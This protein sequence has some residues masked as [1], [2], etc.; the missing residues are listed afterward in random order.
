MRL[1]NREKRLVAYLRTRN[2]N[3]KELAATLNV[4]Q[5][6]I[7]RDIRHANSV[8]KACG[9]GYIDTSSHYHLEVGSITALDQLLEDI[10]DEPTEVLLVLLCSTHPT[11]QQLIEKTF[12]SPTR[13]RNAIKVINAQ[14]KAVLQIKPRTGHGLEMCFYKMQ[15]ADLLAALLVK[16]KHAKHIVSKYTVHMPS[17]VGLLRCEINNYE[18]CV[19]SWVTPRQVMLQVE[20][21]LITAGVVSREALYQKERINAIKDYFCKKKNLFT[22]LTAHRDVLEQKAHDLLHAHGMYNKTFDLESRIFDHIVREA[23]FPTL[24][25]DEFFTQAEELQRSYP[26][27]FDFAY[28]Y[29]EYLEAQR[30]DM[31]VVPEL[32]A[33]YV[34][35]TH[36][37][38]TSAQTNILLLCTRKSLEQVN[39]SVIKQIFMDSNITIVNTYLDAKQMY[40]H[41]KFDVLIYDD[42]ISISDVKEL[43]WDFSYRGI[44]REDDLRL[45]QKRL[46]YANY[47]K[48]I[49]QMLPQE[50][51]CI[52]TTSNKQYQDVLQEALDLFI[53]RKCMTEQE[54]RSIQ[55]RETQSNR[56]CFNTI[57]VPHCVTEVYSNTFRL[58][59]IMLD[60]PLYEDEEEIRIILIVLASA[61][62]QDKNTIFSYLYKV[63]SMQE[64]YQQ[65]ISYQALIN[66]LGQVKL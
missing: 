55:K 29:C 60:P 46:L 23:L 20:A 12:L 56:L 66:F 22:W 36:V 7:F 27:E 43:P 32:C 11:M 33:L 30:K 1:N 5:R 49:T 57:A 18:E 31:F 42:S 52:L 45:L 35:G 10:C 54:G 58:F 53:S 50:H 2:V 59:A 51:F 3:G 34:I 28:M 38:L 21:A 48:T 14:Y 9:A 64:K 47:C 37:N 15:A 6:T 24:M 19:N 65:P 17:A 25:N 39:L 63:F 26:F 61:H 16:Y 62:Q 44:I 4:S 40:S 13:I 8:L 41:K